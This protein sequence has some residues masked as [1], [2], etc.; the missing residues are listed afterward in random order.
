MEE[1]RLCQERLGLWPC[2]LTPGIGLGL[3]PRALTLGHVSL[4]ERSA[5]MGWAGLSLL[6]WRSG[7]GLSV[8]G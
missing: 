8:Q 3:W 1:Q 5:Q 7:M 4:Y 6:F 2:A